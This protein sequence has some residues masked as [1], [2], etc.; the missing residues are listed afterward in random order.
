MVLVLLALV[1]GAGFTQ[2]CGSICSPAAAQLHACCDHPG[3]PASTLAHPVCHHA[4]QPAPAPAGIALDGNDY[5]STP[6]MWVTA[7]QHR[8]L[9]E[10]G[11]RALVSM[12]S[13]PAG[14]L[15]ASASLPL[16]I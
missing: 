11:R 5:P 2:L 9:P 7:D 4:V 8:A 12:H 3:A 15:P 10:S 6:V 13:P 1:T 14:L 16:R